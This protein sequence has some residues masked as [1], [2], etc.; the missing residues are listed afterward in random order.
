MHD[1]SG[2][3]AQFDACGGKGAVAIGDDAELP[4]DLRSSDRN[5]HQVEV[6]SFQANEGRNDGDTDAAADQAELGVKMTDLQIACQAVLKRAES[7][8][9]QLVLPV[10]LFAA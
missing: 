10:E 5:G 6:G 9:E 8:F 7:L 3:I 4:V 2:D 1:G